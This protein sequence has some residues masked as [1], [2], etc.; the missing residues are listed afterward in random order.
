MQCFY[1]VFVFLYNIGHN[2]FYRIEVNMGMFGTDNEKSTIIDE[3]IKWFVDIVLAVIIAIF[4]ITYFCYDVDISGNSMN[5]ILE[6]R[7]KVLINELS[8]EIKAPERFDV[9]AYISRGNEI[10]VKRIIGLPGETVQIVD[11]I[12]YIDGEPLK[13]TY[14]EGKFESG[15]VKEA[16]VIG[17]DEYFVMGDNRNVSED[18]RFEYVGNIKAKDILGKVWFVCAPFKKIR[19]I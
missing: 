5:P 16:V 13:D 18:S 8:Y 2:I 14:Y 15:Y 6:D 17:N 10:S 12:I 7:E 11:N 19:I 4:V 1:V 3:I 9:V